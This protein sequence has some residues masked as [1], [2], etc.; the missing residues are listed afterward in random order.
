MGW[1]TPAPSWGPWAQRG[2]EWVGR[3]IKKVNNLSFDGFPSRGLRAQAGAEGWELHY[4]LA[5]EWRWW[6]LKLLG[7]AP[8][9]VEIKGLS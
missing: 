3:K 7:L 6:P 2:A 9:R 1:R 8:A 5:R 4:R